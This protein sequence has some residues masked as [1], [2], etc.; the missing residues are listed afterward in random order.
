MKKTW[1]HFLFLMLMVASRSTL[2][3]Q[4][5]DS[6]GSSYRI[7][8]QSLFRSTDSLTH[9][10]TSLDDFH[11]YHPAFRTNFGFLDL[12]N[13]GTAQYPLI[14]K[15]SEQTG[16][17]LGWHYM[18]VNRFL[19]SENA[20]LY[21]SKKPITS[22]FYT[23]GANELI[24]LNALHAQNIKPNWSFGV[25]FRRLKENGFYQNQRTGQYNT[26][27]F[28]WYHSKDFRY[29]LIASATWNRINNQ[30]NGGIFSRESFDTLDGPARSPNVRFQDQNARNT[31][32]SNQ[33]EL[34]QLYRLGQY[35][36]FPTEAVD[37]LGR[38]VPDTIPTL[39]QRAQLSLTTG[40]Q[41]Y[42][43]TFEIDQLLGLGMEKFY[44]DSATTFDSTW[45]RDAYVR[46]GIQSGAFQKLATDSLHAK[47]AK[48]FASLSLEMHAIRVGWLE[49]YAA[50]NNVSLHGEL[51]NR[52]WVTKR[53]GLFLKGYY[54]FS[55]YNAGDYD[56]Q[57]KG[58][59]EIWK[60]RFGAGMRFKGYSPDFFSYYYFGNHHFWFNQ[61]LRRQIADELSAF[62]SNQGKREWIRLSGRASEI[63]N[64]IYLA[65][66][67]TIQQ[68]G[69]VKVLQADLQLKYDYK[70]FHWQTSVIWQQSDKNDELPLARFASR[71]SI[72][73]QGW[74]FKHNLKARFGA[75]MFWCSEFNAP[76]YVPALRNWKIQNPDEAFTIGD[77]PYINV[78]F[79]GEIRTV[80]F[81]FMMQH[82][83]DGAFGTGYYASPYYPMQPRSFRFGIRWKMYE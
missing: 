35:R 14:F 77:Y 49:D 51:A 28:N 71:S 16:F 4:S 26:R 70:W 50:Y 22:L 11:L 47:P 12:G 78:Y 21:K 57:A 69:A 30:E 38:A 60:L 54:G 67:E 6:Y 7:T 2:L 45:F 75:D 44:R 58:E 37:S 76:A 61:T 34:T 81:F 55:G 64:M 10:D 68:L 24:G 27:V 5:D 83:T 53:E 32:K 36:Y 42:T 63:R 59:R 41:T 20:H 72:F 48:W 3:A 25:E 15:L 17:D 65:N 66:D 74:L 8:L 79:T 23:Q 43:N 40:I 80:T 56:F 62:I 29:H 18:D 9:L 82:V 13:S 52:S 19:P 39:I 1:F 46:V 33:F 73:F 31:L